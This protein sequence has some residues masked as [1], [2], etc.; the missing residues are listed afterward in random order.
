GTPEIGKPSAASASAGM[1]ELSSGPSA[2]SSA[3]N[4]NFGCLW[5]RAHQHH[6]ARWPQRRSPTCSSS[7]PPD[8]E[9]A[10]AADD[11]LGFALS[12]SRAPVARDPRRAFVTEVPASFGNSRRPVSS[13]AGL[14]R[15]TTGAADG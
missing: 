11:L 10:V 1:L 8:G 3:R 9:R 4:R 2:R 6:R 7:A 14:K 12:P 15:N 5:W 13:P